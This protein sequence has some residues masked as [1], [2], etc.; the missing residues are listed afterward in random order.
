MSEPQH[1]IES[2]E[3]NWNNAIKLCI[4]RT[5][6]RDEA[7]ERIAAVEAERDTLAEELADWKDCAKSAAQEDCGKEKHCS[8]VPLLRKRV[9]ELQSVVDR[10][11]NHRALLDIGEERMRQV[12]IEGWTEAHDDKWINAELAAAAAS[13]AWPRDGKMQDGRIVPKQWP[14]HWSWWKVAGQRRNLI[15]AGALIVAEIERL[16]RVE[17]AS[18]SAQQVREGD[19]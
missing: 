18:Q 1:T 14:W 19:K 9:A 5:K 8:C 13:Y 17:L 2:L 6:E 10:L 3:T 15:K 16:D 12:E 4:K 11:P 7:L